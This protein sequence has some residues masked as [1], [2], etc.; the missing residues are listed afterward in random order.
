MA[1][2]HVSEHEVSI[3]S[4]ILDEQTQTLYRHTD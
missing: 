1:Y 3:Y 4:D 2:L